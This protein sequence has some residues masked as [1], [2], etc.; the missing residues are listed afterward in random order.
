MINSFLEKELKGI[1]D[2]KLKGNS[3]YVYLKGYYEPT[4]KIDA[5]GIGGYDRGNLVYI[6]NFGSLENNILAFVIK[7]GKSSEEK[8]A[9]VKKL[10]DEVRALK[11]TQSNEEIIK[12]V[13]LDR[14]VDEYLKNNND[15]T[16]EPYEKNYSVILLNKDNLHETIFVD[17]ENTTKYYLDVINLIIN[18]TYVENIIKDNMFN[19]TPELLMQ[20]ISYSTKGWWTKVEEKKEEQNYTE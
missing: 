12:S 10:R 9:K 15:I 16:V 17:K 4:Y 18:K 1:Y 13:G 7:Y 8:D 2:Y 11:G 6:T 14:I 5:T 19:I 3:L 20:I